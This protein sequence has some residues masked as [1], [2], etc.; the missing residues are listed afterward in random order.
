MVLISGSLGRNLQKLGGTARGAVAPSPHGR[1]RRERRVGF[2]DIHLGNAARMVLVVEPTN[3]E[4][5]L[6][7]D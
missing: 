6:P 3:A 2:Q 1:Y 7:C 4:R 5:A